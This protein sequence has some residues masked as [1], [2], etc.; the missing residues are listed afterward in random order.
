MC[1]KN[2]WYRF[3][4]P[5][6]PPYQ[7]IDHT[8]QS[9]QPLQ[10]FTS[11]L[12]TQARL[13]LARV[14]NSRHSSR[15]SG[16]KV[17]MESPLKSCFDA[18]TKI[19]RGFRT[20]QTHFQWWFSAKTPLARARIAIFPCFTQL[21]HF[22]SKPPSMHNETRIWRQPWPEN[23]A[24]PDAPLSDNLHARQTYCQKHLGFYTVC[25][26]FNEHTMLFNAINISLFLDKDL[27]WT[28]PFLYIYIYT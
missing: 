24:L 7:W 10:Y 8:W 20:M 13:N 22:E 9:P 6:L 5:I 28:P 14:A 11:S 27:V 26:V 25:C 17:V 19:F 18:S 12:T 3:R 16:K 4:Y 15:L 1:T 21:C 2:L 23:V